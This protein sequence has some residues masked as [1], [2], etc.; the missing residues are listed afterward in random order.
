MQIVPL[1]P[2]PN[3][4]LQIVLAGQNCAIELRS[5]DGY[6][7]TDTVSFDGAQPYIAFSLE[8]SGVSITRTQNCLNRKRLLVNR[9]YLGF[10]GD[11]MFIDTQGQDD[12]QYTGLGTRWLLVYIEAADLEAAA[13]VAAAA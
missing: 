3:Q 7:T 2:N 12:P 6:A 13:A 10:V 4:T 1:A 9:Q 8:V 11:F 5:L